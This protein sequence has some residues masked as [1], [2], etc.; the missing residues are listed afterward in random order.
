MQFS[1]KDGLV[2]DSINAVSELSVESGRQ[3]IDFTDGYIENLSGFVMSGVY[4]PSGETADMSDISLSSVITT[5]KVTIS[6]PDNPYVYTA[7]TLKIHRDVP[8]SL[9]IK[10]ITADRGIIVFNEYTAATRSPCPKPHRAPI[11]R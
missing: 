7:F 5:V 4:L 10:D 6:V 1:D 8:A 2:F 9:S 3:T 11:Y